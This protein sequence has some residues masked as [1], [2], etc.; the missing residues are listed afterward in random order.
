MS[1]DTMDNVFNLVEPNGVLSE[2]VLLALREMFGGRLIRE[3]AGMKAHQLTAEVMAC[4]NALFPQ[5]VTSLDV[6]TALL[7]IVRQLEF[8]QESTEPDEHVSEPQVE[9][10]VEATKTAEY[11]SDEW[12]HDQLRAA[13][14]D[15]ITTSSDI[16]LKRSVVNRISTMSGD[17]KLKDTIVT[18]SVRTMSGDIR[19]NIFVGHGVQ[20]QT[21]SGDIT[22]DIKQLSWPRLY[23]KAVELG[24]I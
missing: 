5:N 10:C 24:V 13:A 1:T 20:V 19:G 17:V 12:Y 16:N 21:M 18:H 4:R 7:N 3:I 9:Q 11:H 23:A 6:A 8:V 15:S 22:A 2:D 14:G